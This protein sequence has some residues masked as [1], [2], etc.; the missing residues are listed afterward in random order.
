M[1]YRKPRFICDR[2]GKEF[3]YKQ[4]VK[5]QVAEGKRF[6]FDVCDQCIEKLQDFLM[7]VPED[8]PLIGFRVNN[9]ERED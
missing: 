5:V 8:E 6:K 3:A 4:V 2:C 9:K 7:P 1:K